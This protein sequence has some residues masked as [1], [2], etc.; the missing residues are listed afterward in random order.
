MSK[1]YKRQGINSIM[2][3]HGLVKILLLYHLSKIGDNWETFLIRNGFTQSDATVNPLLIVNPNLDRP[4]T[5]IQVVNSIDGLQFVESVSVVVET[6]MGKE[7]PCRFSPR[8]SL[9]QLIS[10]L[11][12][13]DRHVPMDDTILNVNDK[14]VVKNFRKGKK[15]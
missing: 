3:H 7:L 8:K 5:E 10:K 4:V 13:K 6:P 15:P 9:E 1:S 12:E 14:P 11:K 2:F